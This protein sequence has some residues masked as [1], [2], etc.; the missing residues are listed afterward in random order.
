MVNGRLV[1]TDDLG[2]TDTYHFASSIGT[3]NPGDALTVRVDGLDASIL[4]TA[5]VVFD[6]VSSG[7]TYTDAVPISAV[8]P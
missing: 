2:G 5:A 6:E 7:T 1:T 4:R 8:N 3:L